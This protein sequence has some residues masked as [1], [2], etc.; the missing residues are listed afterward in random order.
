MTAYDKRVLLMRHATA[1]EA[2]AEHGSQRIL[3]GYTMHRSRSGLLS[4][5]R[6]RGEQ[7]VALMRLTDD[8]P[9]EFLKPASRGIRFGDWLVRFSGRTQREAI[10]SGELP[11]VADTVPGDAANLAPVA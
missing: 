1:Y 5:A 7:L 10:D 4:L 6:K 11:F 2:V 8:S 9:V 3:I